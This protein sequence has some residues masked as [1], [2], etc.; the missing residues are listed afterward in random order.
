LELELRRARLE[1]V[2]IGESK[3]IPICPRRMQ[4]LS[5]ISEEDCLERMMRC[6][7]QKR[8]MGIWKKVM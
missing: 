7:P 8:G 6:I 3:I 2:D 1:E 4:M 5:G